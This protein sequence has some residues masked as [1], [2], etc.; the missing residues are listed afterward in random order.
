MP[1]LSALVVMAGLLASL[2]AHAQE[3]PYGRTQRP[4]LSPLSF[5]VDGAQSGDIGLVD[6]FP[7]LRF[8]RPLVFAVA[9]GDRTRAFVAEQRG[10]IHVFQ[11]H[12]ATAASSAFLDLSD[13]VI[14]EGNEMGLLGLA[15]DPQYA[16]NGYFYVNYIPAAGVRRTRIARFRRG[17]DADTADPASETVLLEYEQP[18]RNHNGGWLGFGQD[19]KLYIA[20]GD[21]GS[22][23]DPENRAQDFSSLLGK[24]LRINKDGTIPADN[25]FF[26]QA[27]RRGEIW[28]LG[29]R[30]PYRAGFDRA[31]GELWVGDVGPASFEEV[32]L[33]IRAGNYGWRKYKGFVVANETDPV[34]ENN[35]FPI[36]VYT[37]SGVHC[38][39]SGGYVYR[40][41]M[42][43]KL[44]GRYLYADYCSAT[45]W[46]LSW[47]GSALRANDVLG[48][49]PGNPTSFGEDHDG[50]LYITSF[51]GAVYKI[52]PGTA[53]SS[54]FP[55]KLSE[56]GLFRDTAALIPNKGLL[57]YSVNAPLWS[58]N[59]LKT[60]WIGLPNDQQIGFS[61]AGPWTWPTGSVLVKHFERRLADQSIKRL[62]TRVLINQNAGWQGYTYRWNDAGTDAEL[63]GE[64]QTTS[65]LIADGQGGSRSVTYEFPGR[66][67]CLG[68]HTVAAG[69][70]LGARSAQLNR[71]RLYGN[72]VID[73]Q[74]RSFDHIGLFT[75]PIGDPA[76]YPRLANPRDTSASLAARARAY[77]D[78]NCAQCHRP[79][80]P[81][82]VEMDLRAEVPIGNTNTVD[83]PP[84][85]G[86][87]GVADARR[88]A[89]GNKAASLLWLRMRRLDEH[90][91]PPLASHLIDGRGVRLIGDW[92]DAGA[93]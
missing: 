15:F 64:A 35:I 38:A 50:E 87:L 66:A 23:G 30:N 34:P 53:P 26:D 3:P 73:N 39:I 32:N 69:R 14:Q 47:D 82:P 85:Q 44:N 80:G 88:I 75:A 10:R 71:E 42:I 6:A 40:G 78:S 25:P 24:I 11:N 58:D 5:P 62:E 36:L 19:G 61:A 81:T 51:D 60:R 29:F 72:G 4:V 46:S 70:V 63:L 56:T 57:Q 92:I 67:A 16:S 45:L 18:Y 7:Q 21:G 9:P 31:T 12:A 74:L 20:S 83:V 54:P 28:A 76:Q 1:A 43:P 17:A 41:G 27:G 22:Q 49:V 84:T 13:R 90:R 52:V 55:Q 68:C 33:V 79:G 77:L 8:E 91:M 93:Q 89:A 86:N 37:H 65:L 48:L 2:M 59:T